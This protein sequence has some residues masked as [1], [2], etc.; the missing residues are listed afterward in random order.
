MLFAFCPEYPNFIASEH[1]KLYFDNKS[2]LF[3]KSNNCDSYRRATVHLNPLSHFSFLNSYTFTSGLLKEW[4]FHF[5]QALY[6][7]VTAMNVKQWWPHGM[8]ASSAG[9]IDSREPRASD[10][11]THLWL[12]M[13]L[14]STF[15]LVLGPLHFYVRSHWAMQLKTSCCL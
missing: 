12:C 7:K 2:I 11:L 14:L 6:S 15:I 5:S 9:R 3:K 4:W 13:C 8:K 10:P 1:L